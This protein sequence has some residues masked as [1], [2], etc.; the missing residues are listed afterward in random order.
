MS[1]TSPVTD[2]ASLLSVGLAPE[3][4]VIRPKLQPANSPK[5][6]PTAA[7]WGVPNAE[8]N[9]LSQLSCLPA[10]RASR[11]WTLDQTIA[12]KSVGRFGR[13][14]LAR[15]L[16]SSSKRDSSIFFVEQ[17]YLL[18]LFNETKG[19]IPQN[20]GTL[21]YKQ[22]LFIET[23]LCRVANS[24]PVGSLRGSRGSQVSFFSET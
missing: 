20:F 16:R 8:S 1:I 23:R 18:S 4:V 17:P 10:D 6:T 15:A 11:F 19:L 12:L 2:A 14:R 22:R 5:A 13:G 24:A 3:P 21:F 7:H 9:A